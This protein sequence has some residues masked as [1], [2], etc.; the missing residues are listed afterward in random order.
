M[1]FEKVVR[2]AGFALGLSMLS[3]GLAGPAQA[4]DLEDAVEAADASAGEAQ[5]RRCMSCHTVEEGGPTRQGPNL[6]GIVDR[7]IGSVEGFRYSRALAGSEETWTLENLNAFIEN[8]R[9]ARPGTNMSFP[10][11]RREGDRM[12]LLAYL[13][14]LQAGSDAEEESGDEAAMESQ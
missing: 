13:Q 14:T 10:G 4:S 8:P 5:F 1:S 11:L 6:W 7:Q 9:A 3:M 12:D 2:G